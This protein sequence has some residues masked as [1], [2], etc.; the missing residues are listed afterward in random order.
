MKLETKNARTEHELAVIDAVVRGGGQAR[1]E[2]A[3]LVDFALLLRGVRPLPDRGA[4]VRIDERVES[5]AAARRE[6][7]YPVAQFGAAFACLILVLGV[8]A[9]T[10]LGGGHDMKN[11]NTDAPAGASGAAAESGVEGSG[12]THAEGNE[13]SLQEFGK[14]TQKEFLPMGAEPAGVK[15]APYDAATPRKQERS[16]SL[17]LVT[18]PGRFDAAAD[19]IAEIARAAGGYVQS[20]STK[21]T[22]RDRARGNFLVMVPV[23]GYRDALAAFSKL[24]HVRTQSEGSQDITSEYDSAQRTLTG[25]RSRTDRIKD[26]LAQTTDPAQ[27]ASL[28]RRLNRA[29]IAEH[30]AAQRARSTRYRANYVPVSVVLGVARDAERDESGPIARAF[31]RA[32]EILERLLAAV[33]VLLAVAL[34]VGAALLAV[35]WVTRLVRRSR[36]DRA[37]AGAATQPE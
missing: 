28:R 25:R 17:S 2:D 5:A 29:R 23:A 19:R 18:T 3:E 22:D 4:A 20:A 1:P 9:A 11:I 13:R 35:W 34:P 27:R 33:I 12:A 6:R 16:A 7:R 15:Q 37:V 30:Q 14:G 31:D 32:G 24:G 26:Q 8:V 36:A 10:Q 21:V